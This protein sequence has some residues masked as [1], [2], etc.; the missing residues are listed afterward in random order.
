MNSNSFGSPIGMYG[1]MPSAPSA[2]FHT[3]QRLPGNVPQAHEGVVVSPE[4]VFAHHPGMRPVHSRKH[5][6]HT[7][8]MRGGPARFNRFHA[9]SSLTRQQRRAQRRLLRL[10]TQHRP[11]ESMTIQQIF[12]AGAQLS[13]QG[14]LGPPDPALPG[15]PTLAPV[16]TGR[17]T[18]VSYSNLWAAYPRRGRLDFMTGMPVALRNG[19]ALRTP[20][21]Q[22]P[23]PAPTG[24]FSNLFARFTTP[25]QLPH[26]QPT[27]GFGDPQF[28][29]HS[30]GSYQ[31]LYGDAY[32]KGGG[33]GT[34]IHPVI[35]KKMSYRVVSGRKSNGKP[36]GYVYWQWKNGDITIVLSPRSSGQTFLAAADQSN[37]WKAIT[38]QIGGGVSASSVAFRIGA[39]TNQL[40]QM[41]PTST[42][43]ASIDADTP[44]AELAPTDATE[45]FQLSTGAKIGIGVGGLLTVGL[46]VALAAGG[47][48]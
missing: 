8:T 33:G 25:F 47:R 9:P 13:P 40:S 12:A 42:A 29:G 4:G 27:A 41:L 26:A 23:P 35:G 2:F 7:H 10:A 37:A 1:L 28:G 45:P 19:A 31:V 46:L 43:V 5:P 30:V 15:V 11:A 20:W 48:R 36:D 32:G 21:A 17:Y 18:G 16:P 3:A 22:L 6:V 34:A 39:L 38:A 24:F 44:G 14:R